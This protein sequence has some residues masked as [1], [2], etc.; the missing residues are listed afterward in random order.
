M[1][2]EVN[3][4]LTANSITSIFLNYEPADTVNCTMLF[5]YAGSPPEGEGVMRLP[6]L[7]V[8]VRNASDA[9]AETTI[10]TIYNLLAKK[11]GG[12]LESQG[13]RAT[14]QQ[15]PF[16]FGRADANEVN[17]YSEWVCNFEVREP[18]TAHEV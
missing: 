15:A 1:L 6:R 13:L 17:Q 9:T 7:Q 5:Q 12:L 11:S 3:T 4:Y 18:S 10:T 8:R 14:P 16:H 2:S